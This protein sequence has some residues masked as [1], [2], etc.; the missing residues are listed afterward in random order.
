MVSSV[1]GAIVDEEDEVVTD[2]RRLGSSDVWA[3]SD[4][5]EPMSQARR[6]K[7]VR[8]RRTGA[9]RVAPALEKKIDGGGAQRSSGRRRLGQWWWMDGARAVRAGGG[10]L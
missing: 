7:E 9:E 2:E 4:E 6:L 1:A 8:W 5:V 3:H 10:Y